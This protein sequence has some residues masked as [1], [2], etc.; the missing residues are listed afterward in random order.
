M[1]KSSINTN[2]LKKDF[3]KFNSLTIRE[4]RRGPSFG[5]IEYLIP[6][7]LQIVLN[8]YIPRVFFDRPCHV[9]SFWDGDIV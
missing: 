3:T 4:T 5:H 2:N 8:I 1:S 6:N 7:A 9:E